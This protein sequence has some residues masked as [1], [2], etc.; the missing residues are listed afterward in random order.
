MFDPVQFMIGGDLKEMDVS[1]T[2]SFSCV[3]HPPLRVNMPSCIHFWLKMVKMFA[4]AAL[5]AL[6][7]FCCLVLGLL[8]NIDSSILMYIN[9]I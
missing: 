3:V 7:F 2:H 1:Y 6:V 9:V 4:F 8:V 5:G